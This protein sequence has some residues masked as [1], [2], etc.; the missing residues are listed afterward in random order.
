MEA[1]D[2]QED[3]LENE[4]FK[5]VKLKFPSTFELVENNGYLLCV[6][7]QSSLS[8]LSSVDQSFV[9]SHILK[10]SPLDEDEYS[11]HNNPNKSVRIIGNQLTPLAGYPSESAVQIRFE[12]LF[13]GRTERSYRVLCIQRPLLPLASP[14]PSLARTTSAANI[15]RLGPLSVAQLSRIRTL[16]E[17]RQL[18]ESWPENDL[19][20][21]KVQGQ[22]Q[23]FAHSYVIVRGFESQLIERVRQLVEFAVEQLLCANKE[24]RAVQHN[25]I[26][27]RDLSLVIESFVLGGMYAKLFLGLT[28][29]FES[30]DQFLHAIILHYATNGLSLEHLGVKR[31]FQQV[32]DMEHV[33]SMLAKIDHEAVTPLEKYYL[34]RSCLEHV[35]KSV[36][37][38]L[39][40]KNSTATHQGLY[41]HTFEESV[42][43]SQQAEKAAI[44][45]DDWIPLLVCM[46]IKADLQ[47]LH[48]NM[49]MLEHF[50][51][52]KISTTEIGFTIVNFKAA[53]EYL[54]SDELQRAFQ[55]YERGRVKARARNQL[56][57][58]VTS[59]AP[60][61]SSVTAVTEHPLAPLGHVASDDRALNRSVSAR[62]I[63]R[64]EMQDRRRTVAYGPSSSAYGTSYHAPEVINVNENN[65]KNDALSHLKSLGDSSMF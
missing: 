11:A 19:V 64:A 8:D 27:L 50:F 22:V 60:R 1:D 6:P 49:F 55:D 25:S 31:E 46:I 4:F 54:K 65:N 40:S 56:R 39:K 38:G 44:T 12:E 48:T 18:L 14:G 13:Y 53:V 32:I 20:L 45:T 43:H 59:T 26:V 57:R 37:E 17:C 21:K 47:H 41:T 16:D 52:T 35:D 34:I 3:L 15:A 23:S 24:F 7:Q 5:L 61:M 30:E 9:D 2:Q 33:A 42:N 29:V 63:S 36:R 10:Q 58:S 51:Y 28:A 62:T